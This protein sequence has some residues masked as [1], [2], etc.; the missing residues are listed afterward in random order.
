MTCELSRAPRGEEKG[1]K[2]RTC[3]SYNLLHFQMNFHSTLQ[4]ESVECDFPS[5]RS[6]FTALEW[7]FRLLVVLHVDVN[8]VVSH[9]IHLSLF[10]SAERRKTHSSN[11]N[12][13]WS[14]N[15]S[16]SK[17]EASKCHQIEIF[18]RVQSPHHHQL[19]TVASK[20]SQRGVVS[21]IERWLLWSPCC[22]C[23]HSIS[24]RHCS[25]FVI[26]V[27]FSSLSLLP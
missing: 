6:S 7:L 9:E 14:I 4:V 17:R 8:N 22:C 24:H 27:L 26:L 10:R 12:L 25:S 18:S 16:V 21:Y 20:S 19:A 3:Q 1:E 2:K 13:K 15:R 11:G 5:P 23:A